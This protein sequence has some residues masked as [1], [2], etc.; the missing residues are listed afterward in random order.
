MTMHC[1]WVHP[2]IKPVWRSLQ[3][4]GYTY[5]QETSYILII[6]AVVRLHKHLYVSRG[7]QCSIGGLGFKL[8]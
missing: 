5:E 3:C 8:W 4:A 1:V 2:V 6:A 7:A